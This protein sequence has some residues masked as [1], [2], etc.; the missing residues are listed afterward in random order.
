ML[1]KVVKMGSS[2][3]VCEK[4]N[5][6]INNYLLLTKAGKC[7]LIVIMCE[8]ECTLQAEKVL[9]SSCFLIQITEG[10]VLKVT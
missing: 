4:Y 10:A 3:K 1:S 5:K 8:Q 9:G 2:L 6:E 7:R